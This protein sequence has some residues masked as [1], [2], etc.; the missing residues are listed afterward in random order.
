[1]AEGAFRA[2]AGD[3]AGGVAQWPE[4]LADAGQQGGVGA[5]GEVG[6]SDAAGK[7]HVADEGAGGLWR[8]EDDV[9]GGVPR[10]VV[11]GD[12]AV[13]ESEGVAFAQ[14]ARGG[15]GLGGFFKA[16]GG[17]LLREGVE[18][19]RIGFVRADDRDAEC[20]CQRAGAAHMVDVSV[21]E[22]DVARCDAE[23]VQ[24]RFNARGFAARV[25]DG[26]LFGFAAP[27]DGA[28]L[29]ER[30]DGEGVVV[31]HGAQS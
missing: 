25:N 19:E 10:G 2:V 9:P 30:G 7:E 11:H 18:P 4:A 5:A 22:P 26:G 27:D 31:E 6:A 15:E 17:G 12:G 13:A 3:E 21:G 24:R 1:M 16:E 28:V 23:F 14:P 20:V 8:V 29:L